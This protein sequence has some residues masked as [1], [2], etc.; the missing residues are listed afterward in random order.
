MLVMPKGFVGIWRQLGP[1]KK[2]NVSYQG[3]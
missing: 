3:Q 1:I 2:L